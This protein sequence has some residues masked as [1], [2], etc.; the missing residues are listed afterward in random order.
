MLKLLTILLLMPS[1]M[2][3]QAI[4]SLSTCWPSERPLGYI[5]NRSSFANTADFTL[6]G[7]MTMSSNGSAI[8]IGGGA[9]TFDR[10][11]T[12]LTPHSF[13]NYAITM[14]V[15]MINAADNSSYGVGIGL[16]SINAS[17]PE[18]IFGW[19][20]LSTVSTPGQLLL[21][22]SSGRLL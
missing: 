16:R 22:N 21:Y 14:D 20:N 3:G 19:V 13:S 15:K 12:L 11:A 4:G 17:F 6:K 18:D 10:Y 9:G 8:N 1:M 5:Y 7:G 2:F